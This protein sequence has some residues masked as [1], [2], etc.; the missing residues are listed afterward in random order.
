MYFRYSLSINSRSV[1]PV[2]NHAS[3]SSIRA[4]HP[5]C[6]FIFNAFRVSR[7]VSL[8]WIEGHLKGHSDKNWTYIL[9]A[10][11]VDGALISLN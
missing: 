9:N 11:P 2:L 6:S 8:K 10:N 5:V 4:E 7:R 1:K 3:R